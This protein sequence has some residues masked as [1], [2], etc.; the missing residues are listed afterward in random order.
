MTLAFS[1]KNRNQPNERRRKAGQQERSHRE[2]HAVQAKPV[3]TFQKAGDT[4]NAP[5][6]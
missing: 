6:A 1:A 5:L 3:K 4:K 2:G